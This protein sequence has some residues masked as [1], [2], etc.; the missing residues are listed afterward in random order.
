MHIISFLFPS[1]DVSQDVAT[2]HSPLSEC[3]KHSSAWK[4]PKKGNVNS[5]FSGGRYCGGHHYWRFPD[6]H[7]LREKSSHHIIQHRRIYTN[8]HRDEWCSW[9]YLE[10]HQF[11]QQ[12]HR[13]SRGALALCYQRLL[14]IICKLHQPDASQDTCST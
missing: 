6:A 9:N 2:S 7:Q 4:L 1:L 3:L 14:L 13:H 12:R 8:E 11:R 10:E 5:K